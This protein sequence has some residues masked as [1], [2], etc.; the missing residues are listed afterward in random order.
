MLFIL[1]LSLD[2][3]LL[4]QQH[5]YTKQFNML[6]AEVA[7]NQQQLSALNKQY[8]VSDPEN[9]EKTLKSLQQQYLNKITSL[10]LLT[11]YANFTAYLI[12]LAKATVSGVWLTKINFNRGENKIVLE[13]YTLNPA[14]LEQFYSKL[15]KESVFSDMLFELNNIQETQL[16]AS[17][18]ITAKKVSMP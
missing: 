6:T 5:K 7:I 3:I 4:L 10:E 14:M 8:P 9:L 1:I 12:G 15:T 17:F 16:P 18:N 11:P 2:L 13:G